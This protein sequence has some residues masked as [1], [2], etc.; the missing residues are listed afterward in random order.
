MEELD[1]KLAA[2]SAALYGEDASLRIVEP[3]SLSLLKRNA[4]TFD[5]DTFRQ[6]TANIRADGRLSSMPL[7]WETPAGDLEVL[8]GNHRVQAAV[9]AGL[10]RILVLVLHGDLSKARR[11]AIQLSHNALVGTDDPTLL[12]ELWAEIDDIEAKLYAGLSSDE[13]SRLE[14]IDLVGFTTPQVYTRTISLAF[15]DTELARFDAVLEQLESLP[16]ETAHMVP[17]EQFERFFKA[18][19]G[20]KTAFEIRNTS[21]AIL[22]MC[23]L[24][25]AALAAMP[26]EREADGAPE[27]RP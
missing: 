15:V 10:A 14:K 3:R 17:L 9:E 22:R 8:S 1:E 24:C 5:K 13:V 6:L 7:C 21:L 25:E 12:A 19:E 20:V 11:I 2:A 23:E 27:A 4:R 26:P 16:G 18:L